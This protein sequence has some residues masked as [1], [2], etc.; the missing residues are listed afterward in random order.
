VESTCVTIF[1]A[2]ELLEVM[3]DK[4]V[5]AY[6]K[7]EYCRFFTNVYVEVRAR[8]DQLALEI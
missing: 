6:V 4:K 1:S 3:M 8:H 7:T 5:P 2:K